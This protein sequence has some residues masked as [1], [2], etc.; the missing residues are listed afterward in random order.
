V[1]RTYN[2]HR[3]AKL[4]ALAPLLLGLVVGCKVAS[5]GDD[6]DAMIGR[7]NTKTFSMDLCLA[8]PLHPVVTHADLGRASANV[9]RLEDAMFGP[10][11]GKAAAAA[12]LLEQMRSTRSLA[13]M[14]RA[15]SYWQAVGRTACAGFGRLEYQGA[16]HDLREARA[17]LQT[18]LGGPGNSRVGR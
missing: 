14:G 5:R 15:I 17:S 8:V 11:P 6:V 2:H 18:Q 3:Q 7:Y 13:S 4:V 12:Y 10:D 16:V 1:T 9:T